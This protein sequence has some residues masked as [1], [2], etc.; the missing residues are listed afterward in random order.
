LLQTRAGA[1]ANSAG[2]P[3]PGEI[4]GLV[5]DLVGRDLVV[6]IDDVR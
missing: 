1:A 3:D 2:F 6:E 4:S 5:T